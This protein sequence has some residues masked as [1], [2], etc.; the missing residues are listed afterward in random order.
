MNQHDQ[1]QSRRDGWQ[2]WRDQEPHLEPWPCTAPPSR[3]TS[4]LVL[5]EGYSGSPGWSVC[6]TTII[7]A[8]RNASFFGAGPDCSGSVISDG[9]NLFRTE[10][11]LHF[12][13]VHRR[14]D[15]H[16]LI[17]STRDWVHSRT[18]AVRRLHTRS[19]RAALRSMRAIPLAA[20]TP[21]GTSLPRINEASPRPTTVTGTALPDAISV[22][23]SGRDPR[24]MA[25]ATGFPMT[26]TTARRC[27]TPGRRMTTQWNRGRLRFVSPLSA[28]ATATAFALT[29]TTV[30]SRATRTKPT[31]TAT[32]FR[33]CLRR[34]RW[35]RWT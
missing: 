12:R 24:K 34:V 35:A 11:E 29:W 13:A 33:G 20:S 17:Q 16:L 21:K 7:A 8:N 14:P 6:G 32:V 10:F 22:P 5:A 15:W 30:P 31:A 2:R 19:W 9:Y 1:R 23:S 27:P 28:T 4:R 18:T 26:A 25:T 3:I